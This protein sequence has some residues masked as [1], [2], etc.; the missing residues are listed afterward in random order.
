MGIRPLQNRSDGEIWQTRRIPA[1]TPFRQKLRKRRSPGQSAQSVN[2]CYL[3]CHPR[4]TWRIFNRTREA[5]WPGFMPLKVQVGPK[6]DLSD[7]KVRQS[8]AVADASVLGKDFCQR[9]S[10]PQTAKSLYRRLIH[11]GPFLPA[12]RSVDGLLTFAVR[13]SARASMISISPGKNLWNG[14]WRAIH[15][16]PT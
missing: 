14:E 15:C 3:H 11:I 2:K 16:G 5:H 4:F 9:R 1:L 7:G 8:L 10:G 13:P 6:Q 12:E